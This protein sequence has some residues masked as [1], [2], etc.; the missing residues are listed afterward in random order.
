MKK[1]IIALIPILLF[2]GCM[3]E[4][5]VT[6]LQAQEKLNALLDAKKL[7]P[8]FTT[9]QDLFVAMDKAPKEMNRGYGDKREI[10]YEFEDGSL[11]VFTLQPMQTGGLVLYMYEIRDKEN[12]IVF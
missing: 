4:E 6:G 8:D 10:V 9:M 12:N 11:L 2:I 1:I 5:Q 3:E 7:Q